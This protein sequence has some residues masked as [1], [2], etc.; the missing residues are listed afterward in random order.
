[1]T[2]ERSLPEVVVL[3]C[4]DNPKQAAWAARLVD[5]DKE[6]AWGKTAE[7]LARAVRASGCYEIIEPQGDVVTVIRHP[8]DDA[9]GNRRLYASRSLRTGRVL[10]VTHS[11]G[12]L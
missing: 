5:G 1:M 4:V 8:G 2:N 9:S 7:A 11:R 6:V 12:R 3:P 10:R